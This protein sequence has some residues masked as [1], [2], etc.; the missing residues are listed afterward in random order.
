MRGYLDESSSSTV[1][2]PWYKW[3]K[4]CDAV[5]I[6]KNRRLALYDTVVDTRLYEKNETSGCSKIIVQCA[7]D[8]H[9][10]VCALVVAFQSLNRFEPVLREYPDLLNKSN[11]SHLILLLLRPM[12]FGIGCFE[13]LLM[14]KDYFQEGVATRFAVSRLIGGYS[15]L[16][17]TPATRRADQR[18]TAL[19]MLTLSVI[20]IEQVCGAGNITAHFMVLLFGVTMCLLAQSESCCHLFFTAGCLGQKASP[21]SARYIDKIYKTHYH[22]DC[23][24]PHLVCLIYL[25]HAKNIAGLR[26]VAKP[27]IIAPDGMCYDKVNFLLWSQY[28]LRRWGQLRSPIHTSHHMTLPGITFWERYQLRGDLRDVVRAEGIISHELLVDPVLTPYGH[29]FEKVLLLNWLEQQTTCPVSRRSLSPGQLISA[30]GLVTI[31][32]QRL[33]ASDSTHLRFHSAVV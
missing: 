21:L 8:A 15:L 30:Q 25:I 3:I 23:V 7:V 27:V 2:L 24:N 6:P 22:A 13:K 26:L 32:K 10:L 29:L 5:H 17:D 31:R 33:I 4:I 16:F 12:A 18:Y 20:S 14:L 9:L 1:S 28:C 11:Q 19:V